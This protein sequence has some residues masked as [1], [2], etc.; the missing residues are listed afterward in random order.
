MD[1]RNFGQLW[2]TF[3]EYKKNIDTLLQSEFD[4]MQEMDFKQKFLIF[5][6]H[7]ILLSCW[8]EV[9]EFIIKLTHYY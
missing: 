4:G 7:T 5:F 3:Q 6:E 9:H 1:F 8:F 2:S